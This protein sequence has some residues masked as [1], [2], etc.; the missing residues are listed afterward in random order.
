MT[1]DTEWKTVDS[2]IHQ[3]VCSV[4]FICQP[5][6]LTILLDV[7]SLGKRNIPYWQTSCDTDMEISQQFSPT[8]Y[9]VIRRLSADMFSRLWLK[10]LKKSI[11]SFCWKLIKTSR[12]SVAVVWTFT[13]GPNESITAYLMWTFIVT[14]DQSEV[15]KFVVAVQ[16]SIKAARDKCNFITFVLQT[17]FV[18]ISWR[19]W[20]SV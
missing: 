5:T 7:Y 17:C 6:I 9:Y 13:S 19:W 2:Y 11:V 12:A 15:W 8:T 10:S 16:D 3:N 1:M 4:R 18:F 20:L 14:T